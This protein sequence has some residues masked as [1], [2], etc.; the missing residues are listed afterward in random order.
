MYPL[1]TR[2]RVYFLRSGV[3][4]YL[5][6]KQRTAI[7]PAYQTYLSDSANRK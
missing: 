5:K 7:K 6:Q 3:V 4:A 1:G 2:G